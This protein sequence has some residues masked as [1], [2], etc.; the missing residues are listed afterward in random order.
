M[1]CG[2][3]GGV[4]GGHLESDLKNQVYANILGTKP[5]SCLRRKIFYEDSFFCF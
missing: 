1:W 3:A 2:F 4:V 5:I